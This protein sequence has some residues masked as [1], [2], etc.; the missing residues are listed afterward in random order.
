MG[1]SAPGLNI[2]FLRW[3]EGLRVL[4]VDDV[5]GQHGSHG[6]GS[7]DNPV[8]TATVSAGD[9]DAGGYTCRLETRDGKSAACRINGKEYDLSKGT[10]FV[11]KAKGAQTEVHQLRRDLAAVPFDLQGC[12]KAVEKDAEIQRRLRPA[13]GPK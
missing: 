4:V 11:I 10:L 1:M 8:Y 13:D 3:K 2:A 12:R 6:T 5:T 7:T 9:A